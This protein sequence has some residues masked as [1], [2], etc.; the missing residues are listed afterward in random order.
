MDGAT[1]YELTMDRS[2]IDED[3]F[4]ETELNILEVLEEGRAT[5]G[6]IADRLDVTPEYVRGRLKELL[7]LE[8]VRKVH[9]GLYELAED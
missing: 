8:L 6:Y 1:V 9:R 4:T 3:E 5:P 7:R 2:D